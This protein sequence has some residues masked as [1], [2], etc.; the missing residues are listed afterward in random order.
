M[1]NNNINLTFFRKQ[2][3]KFKLFFFSS[4]ILSIFLF[5]LD[6]IS[7][8]TILPVILNLDAINLSNAIY[9]QYIPEIF[10]LIVQSLNYKM[11]VIFFIIILFLRNFINILQNL[12]NFYFDKYL[13]IQVSKKIFDLYLRKDFL[14][15]YKIQSNDLL[16]DLRESVVAYCLYV[17][18]VL[19]FFS[20]LTLLLL[21]IFL[22]FF[23][24]FFKTL[25]IS[26]FFIFVVFIFRLLFFKRSEQLGKICNI[27][28]GQLNLTIIELNRNFI[29]IILR[30]LKEKYLNKY[31]SI[32]YK[33]TNSRLF[34]I[35]VKSNTKQF[36]EIFV[37][38]SLVLGIIVFVNLGDLNENLPLLLMYLVATYRIL[39]LVNN[40]SANLIKIKN[41]HYPFNIIQKK[42]NEHNFKYLDFIKDNR[43]GSQLFFKKSLK[44]CGISFKYNKDQNFV[45]KN[46]NLQIKKNE[47]IGIVGESGSGKSTLLKII[48]GIIQPDAGKIIL[49]NNE[50]KKE[51]FPAFQNLLGF[52]SQENTLINATLKENVAFGDS[53][54]NINKVKKSLKLANCNFFIN[55]FKNNLNYIIT[56]HGKNFSIG[57]LQRIGLARMLY[58]DNDILFF[59]EPT[60]ALD[61]KSEL[62]FINL[63]KKFKNYKTIIIS[64]HKKDVLQN[65]DK[66]YEVKNKKLKRVY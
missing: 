62:K 24:S 17:G 51:N 23:I 47:M 32:L 50:V 59:D 26:F 27:S 64:T 34:M 66:I 11:I 14:K 36:L 19:R 8:V 42:I 29:E 65:C 60:S 30:K 58:F 5:F 16:K 13:E 1:E 63:I 15:F 28:S 57:Q 9:I 4:I 53:K 46:L 55:K 18:S 44:L 40:I 61:K 45:F 12:L 33:Y 56:E 35:F 43:T 7:I 21:L 41:F 6:T 39:P 20:E 3:L 22:L 10:F 2:T 49:D 31:L 38:F 48:M 52:L 37:L 25:I 54:I